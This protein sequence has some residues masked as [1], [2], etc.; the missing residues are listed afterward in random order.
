MTEQQFASLMRQARLLTSDYGTGYQRGLRRHYHGERFGS[1]E[2]H[3]R[4]MRF[5]DEPSRAELGRG[6]RDGFAGQPPQPRIGRPPLDPAE[7]SDAK[8]RSIRLGDERWQKLQRLGR[9]WLERQIDR[10]KLP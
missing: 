3:A 5:A 9:A 8:P 4:W 7:R 2:E 1:P 6:Y 10:A